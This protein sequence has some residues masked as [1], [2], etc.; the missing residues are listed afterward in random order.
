MK[1]IYAVVLLVLL[2]GLVFAQ[3]SDS[4]PDQGLPDDAQS[5]DVTR[6]PQFEDGKASVVCDAADKVGGQCRLTNTPQ[7]NSNQAEISA[8]PATPDAGPN[9]GDVDAA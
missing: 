9:G 3:E 5:D 1:I 4:A 2:S 7:P 8:A 6:S